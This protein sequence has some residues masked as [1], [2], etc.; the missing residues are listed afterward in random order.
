M[1]FEV[2]P[3]Q[4][5]C[6]EESLG[7]RSKNENV[8][9]CKTMPARTQFGRAVAG[10][11]DRVD[12]PALPA[13]QRTHRAAVPALCKIAWFLVKEMRIQH[14]A[15]PGA[16]QSFS[17]DDLLA[18]LA[19]G[20]CGAAGHSGETHSARSR[21][22]TRVAEILSVRPGAHT[23]CRSC[24]QSAG[25]TLGNV[26]RRYLRRITRSTRGDRGFQ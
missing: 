25:P 21:A 17:G 23:G 3:L 5:G 1:T 8:Q 12:R 10:V 18:L 2:T 14:I 6:Q 22:E 9:F 20:L 11:R 24:R 19:A 15:T 26:A 16:S 13:G 4:N 7:C